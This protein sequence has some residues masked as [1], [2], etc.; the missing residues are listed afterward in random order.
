MENTKEII[1]Y[2]ALTLFSDRGYEGVS[3]RDIASSVGIKASSIYNHFKSKEDIFNSIIEEMSKRYEEMVLK[4]QVPHGEIDA[5]VEQYM[6]VSYEALNEIARS[7]F[8]YFL[9]DDFASKFRRML[10]V[11][12]FRN[13]QAG[14]I[15]QNF[16]IDGAVD[17]QNLLFHN[18]MGKGA[19]IHCDPYVMALHFYSPIFLLLNKYDRQPD[20]EDEAVDMLR[21]H[22]KQFSDIYTNNS[23]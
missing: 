22:V 12:Q 1:I 18:M 17:F 14:N 23:K 11:E 20:K 16:F 2:R 9:K 5:V 4:M 10:T 15:F 8:L 19:F 3:M 21:K 7:L 13:T 6:Q